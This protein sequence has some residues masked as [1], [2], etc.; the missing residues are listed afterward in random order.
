MLFKIMAALFEESNS[1]WVWLDVE[2][3]ETRD[4]V[5]ISRY[6]QKERRKYTTYCQVRIIDKAY[7]RLYN[8]KAPKKIN[9]S[10]HH[11]FIIMNG[12]YRNKLGNLKPG[13]KVDLEIK[14]IAKPNIFELLRTFTGH[15]DKA[16]VVSSWLGILSF[17]L[18][19]LSLIFAIIALI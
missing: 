4:Y 2:G 6:D 11:N 9:I 1:G 5:K 18:G 14:R 15:P 10:L 8:R 7:V 17:C 13:E 19:F 12:Y 3:F 16:I